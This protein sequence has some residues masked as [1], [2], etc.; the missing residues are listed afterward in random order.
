[1]I[2]EAN[3]T[4]VSFQFSIKYHFPYIFYDY[5][6]H[7]VWI[8]RIDFP[9]EIRRYIFIN[10]ISAFDH[11]DNVFFKD[12]YQN[13]AKYHLGMILTYENHH[14]IAELDF[15]T[16]NAILTRIQRPIKFTELPQ[17]NILS[18]V[19]IE[20]KNDKNKLEPCVVFH[21]LTQLKFYF[22]KTGKIKK[23]HD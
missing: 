19:Q 10:T 8:Q 1:M 3:L 15:S 22:L 7:E 13:K 17:A 21:Y 2:D 14:K 20:G 16:E 18:F 23:H 9:N 11:T 6:K 5:E 12:N 4:D